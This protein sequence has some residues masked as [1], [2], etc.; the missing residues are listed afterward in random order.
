MATSPRTSHHAPKVK[1]RKPNW[2]A[3][4]LL[5]LGMSFFGRFKMVFLV[6]DAWKVAQI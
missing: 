2:G 4:R 5:L 6:C 1:V 3:D